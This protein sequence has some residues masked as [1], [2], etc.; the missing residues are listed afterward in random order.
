[1]TAIELEELY[2]SRLLGRFPYDDCFRIA[3][4][5]P[6][7]SEG[8]IPELDWYFGT[9]AGYCSSASRLGNRPKE[10]LKRAQKSLALSFFEVFPRLAHIENLMTP[11]QTPKLYERM[12]Y[13]EEARLALLDLLNALKID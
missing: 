9:V 4:K 12:K 13:T 2:K 8:L 1:M 7:E 6:I 10:E 11:D 5:E 3:Q